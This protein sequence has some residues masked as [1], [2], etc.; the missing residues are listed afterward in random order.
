M[1]LEWGIEIAPL[2]VLM[3]NVR[4]KMFWK[5]T[6]GSCFLKESAILKTAVRLQW[7]FP[8]EIAKIG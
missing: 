7:F 6:V 3:L 5:T 1:R 2:N 4:L 8:F